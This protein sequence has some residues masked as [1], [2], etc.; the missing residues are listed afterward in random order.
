MFRFWQTNASILASS[1]SQLSG[2]KERE[3]THT[4]EKPYTCKHCKKCFSSSSHCKEH[5]RT[6][7][8]VKP[9]QCKHC[10]RCFSYA[11]NCKEHERTHTGEKPYACKHCKRCFTQSSSCKKHEARHARVRSLKRK[12]HDQ[13]FNPRRDLQEPATTLDDETSCMLFSLSEEVKKIQAK[14]KD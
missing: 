2:Y 14:L 1:S 13:S 12:Q 5:E 3:R 10:K 9:Y 6:H 11:S 4:G 7:T 8:G